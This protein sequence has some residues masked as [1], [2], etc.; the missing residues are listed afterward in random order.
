MNFDI[1]KLKQAERR[2]VVVSNFSSVGV[3][4]HETDDT[5]IFRWREREIREFI[6]ETSLLILFLFGFWGFIALISDQSS[7]N[8]VSNEMI[9][10]ILSIP[11]ALYTIYLLFYSL[12]PALKQTIVVVH[13]DEIRIIR[14]IG[15]FRN[16]KTISRKE[17]LTATEV[18]SQTAL[19]NRVFILN[20]IKAFWAFGSSTTG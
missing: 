6:N 19:P 3:H 1:K 7:G 2:Q 11:I 8:E 10:F 18:E 5:L 14:R 4:V 16:T 12:I 9:W 15:F 17:L 13:H 20:K